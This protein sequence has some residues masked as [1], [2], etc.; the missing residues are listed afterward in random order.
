MPYDSP[1]QAAKTH[2]PA[3]EH[4]PMRKWPKFGKYTS[5]P[6]QNCDHYL[7]AVAVTSRVSI[8][9]NTDLPTP[10]V[11]WLQQLAVPQSVLSKQR[12]MFHEKHTLARASRDSRGWQTIGAEYFGKMFMAVHAGKTPTTK[13]IYFWQA[14]VDSSFCQHFLS[15]TSSFDRTKTNKFL[16]HCIWVYLFIMFIYRVI[17]AELYWYSDT[18][19]TGK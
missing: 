17:S 7:A 11:T 19:S 10:T 15:S 8:E 3:Y 2:A 18:S 16:T 4:I 12:I 5:E 9:I 14:P 13:K 6:C 1:E